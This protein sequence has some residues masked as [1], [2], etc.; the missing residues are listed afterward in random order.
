MYAQ[1]L[2]AVSFA[3]AAYQDAKD[4]AVSDIVWVPAAVG[5]AYVVYTFYSS[6]Q[7][8]N[9]E[10]LLIKIAIIGG[11][12]LVFTFYGSIGQA[13][14][15]AIALVATDP[16]PLSPVLPLLAAA[17]LALSH[18]GYEFTQGNLKKG[19]EVP[20]EQFLREQRWIPKAIVAKDARTEV[21]RDVNVARE[22][23]EAANMPGAMVEV[24]YGVPTAAYLGIGYLAYLVY[25]VVLNYAAF[26]AL[27]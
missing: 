4:R 8:Q 7:F 15:I 14:G 24:G 18:I 25:M 17:V 11:V 16:Y 22:E 20:M 26:A 21:N 12:A 13:D 1:L 6:A 27:P 9:L 19:L 10:F 23:V 3:L 2:I 5:V